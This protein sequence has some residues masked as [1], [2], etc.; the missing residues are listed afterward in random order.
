[1]APAG[2]PDPAAASMERILEIMDTEPEIRDQP[3]ARAPSPA[4][5]ALEICDLSFT[6]PSGER[7]V[8]RGISLR[9]PAG[10]T[11]AIV[12]P[13]GSGKSTL[14]NLL[15][16]LLDPP[17]GTV[18]VDGLDVRDWPLQ[19]LRGMIGMVPQ[20]TFL[21]SDTIGENIAFG[22]TGPTLQEELRHAASASQVIED[23]EAFP[24][25]F[26]TVVGERGITLSGGQKQRIAISRAVAVAPR[27]LILDDSLSNVDT[28]TEERILREILRLKEGRTTILVSHRI[29]AVRNADHIVVLE[30]GRIAEQGTH[31]TLMALGG[32]YAGLYRKQLLEEELAIA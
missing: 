27:I 20:E 22:R 32:A 29:S 23:I 24:G 11:L 1:M 3:G 28:D 15:P 9:L 25:R 6:Y 10:E 2:P 4:R 12:G 14:L 19:S 17:P 31:E 30:E 5:G 8:L 26:G 21:F 16:R 13:T 18:F 7:P